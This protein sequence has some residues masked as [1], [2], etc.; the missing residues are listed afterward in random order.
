MKKQ[1]IMTG[2]RMV[3]EKVIN[4]KGEKLGKIKDITIDMET[5]R[6]AYV[7]LSFGGFLGT[8]EKLFAIPLENFQPAP[9]SNGFILDLSEEELETAEEFD[10]DNWPNHPQ[11]E[12]LNFNQRTSFYDSHKS[13]HNQI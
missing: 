12:F 9:N 11:P 4:T 10:K 3:G 7:A 1:G 5:G 13:T 8:I 6:V 2:T